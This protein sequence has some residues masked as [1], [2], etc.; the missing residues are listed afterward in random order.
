[1][2]ETNL[3]LS[4]QAVWDEDA[5]QFQWSQLVVEKL[6]RNRFPQCRRKAH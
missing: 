4:S 3:D 5:N 6:A 2:L 1:M